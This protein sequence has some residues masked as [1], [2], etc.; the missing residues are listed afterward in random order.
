MSSLGD[1]LRAR[2]AT[3][4]EQRPG[5]ITAAF[6]AGVAEVRAAGIAEGGR[7]VGDLAPDFTLPDT[8]GRPVALADLLAAGPVIVCF[9][10]GGWCPYCN[11]EL[12][13]YEALRAEIAALG[14]TFLAISPE[15]PDVSVTTA[16][17]ESLSFPVLH[18]AGSAVASAFG[19]VHR[20]APAVRAIYE[21]K[22]YDLARRQGLPTEDVSLPL[23]ATYLIDRDRTIRFAFVS[24]DYTERAEP[25]DVLAVARTLRGGRTPD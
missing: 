16:E 3:A 23:P 21:E 13:A 14:V 8:S 24:P 1:Q 6:D 15:T 20:I 5:E 10:R 9:F 7:R 22:G 12:R 25:A 2:H 17:R 18:D 19:I 11:I 4:V